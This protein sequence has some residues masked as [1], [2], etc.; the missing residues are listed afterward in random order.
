MNRKPLSSISV[1]QACSQRKPKLILKL[2]KFYDKAPT[3]MP[4][5]P[6][7]EPEEEEEELPPEEI[8]AQAQQAARCARA[9]LS[10]RHPIVAYTLAYQRGDGS[11]TLRFVNQD[12]YSEQ[13]IKINELNESSSTSSLPIV[14]EN[15]KRHQLLAKHFLENGPF[16]SNASQCDSPFSSISKE[17]LDLLIHTYGSEFLSAICCF[18]NGLCQT[19]RRFSFGVCRSISIGFNQ[20]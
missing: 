6:E 10:S 12:D 20:W 13:R 15:D 3:V 11:T 19:I 7:V 5:E 1:S 2:P 8:L 4:D 17:E 14:N 18:I 9:K 16:S